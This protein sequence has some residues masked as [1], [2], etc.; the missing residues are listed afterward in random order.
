MSVCSQEMGDFK[1]KNYIFGDVAVIVIG[2]GGAKTGG[3]T[4]RLGI[5]IEN[6]W[7]EM[8]NFSLHFGS[9]Q[10]LYTAR[11]PFKDIP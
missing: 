5:F 2:L 8:G 10:T 11:I 3:V 1:K 9:I 4:S 7:K 6:I